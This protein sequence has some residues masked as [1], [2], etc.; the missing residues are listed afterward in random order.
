[1]NPSGTLSIRGNRQIRV[2]GEDDTI[3]LSG[4]VRP[5]DLDSNNSISS[6]LVANLQVSMVGSGQ[7]RDQQ[8]AG[9]GSRVFDWIW[10][11]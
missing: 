10:P 3:R 8:G 9:V 2:N 11:F 7:I 4:V 5:D 6:A 1:V